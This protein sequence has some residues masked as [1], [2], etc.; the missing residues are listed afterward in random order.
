M[1]WGLW[2]FPRIKSYWDSY[3]Y[4]RGRSC[5]CTF[6]YHFICM[7]SNKCTFHWFSEVGFSHL[8]HYSELFKQAETS[9]RGIHHYPSGESRGHRGGVDGHGLWQPF[10]FR[11]SSTFYIIHQII[12][13]WRE[14]SHH[15]LTILLHWEYNN[16]FLYLSVLLHQPADEE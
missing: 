3:G 1:V 6:S 7:K 11:F 12:W 14:H 13:G 2:N 5:V 10:G 4:N 15:I 9:G 8:L 16:I